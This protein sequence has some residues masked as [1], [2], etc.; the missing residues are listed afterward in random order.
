MSKITTG[1]R[2]GLIG[3]LLN[4]HGHYYCKNWGFGAPF[5][6]LIAGDVANFMRRMDQPRNHIFSISDDEGFLASVV[7]DAGAAESGLTHLRWLMV[8]ERARGRGLGHDLVN[9]AVASAR[10]DFMAGLFLWTFEGLTPARRV[11][12]KAGFRLVN[13]HEDRTWGARVLEQRFEL[14]F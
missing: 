14:K 13:E 3:W 7:V 8:A 5:E 4:E 2:P 10:A 11:Y 12:E 9:A 6:T 1:Y